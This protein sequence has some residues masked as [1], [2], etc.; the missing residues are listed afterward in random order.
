MSSVPDE[1]DTSANIDN[2]DTAYMSKLSTDSL[3]GSEPP[4]EVCQF[5]KANQQSFY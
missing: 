2:I 4:V 1:G 5:S 3:S